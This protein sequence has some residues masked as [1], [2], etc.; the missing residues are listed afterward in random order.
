MLF[1]IVVFFG[2]AHAF[3]DNYQTRNLFQF[4]TLINFLINTFRAFFISGAIIT[5][6]VTI[7]RGTK[8][9]VHVVFL[10]YWC[11]DLN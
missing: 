11:L 7:Y 2:F 3:G 8:S 6:H 4:V 9:L 5:Y 10:K 1:E